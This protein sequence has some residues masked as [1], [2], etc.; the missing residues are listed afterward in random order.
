MKDQL[1]GRS[2]SESGDFLYSNCRKRRGW[3]R[4]GHSNLSSFL[5]RGWSIYWLQLKLELAERGVGGERLMGVK[6]VGPAAP[7]PLSS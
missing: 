5:S 2:S 7:P 3:G 1:S 6:A 4:K